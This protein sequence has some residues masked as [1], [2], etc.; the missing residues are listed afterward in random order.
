V[1][2]NTVRIEYNP[3]IF[4]KAI[5]QE[6]SKLYNNDLFSDFVIVSL[7]ASSKFHLTTKQIIGSERIK[8]HKFV[9]G[10]WSPEWREIIAKS[11]KNEVELGSNEEERRYLKIMIEF[12]YK[13]T[14][15]LQS[16]GTE[17]SLCDI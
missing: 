15:S 8:A 13:G 6:W 5:H 7:I 11:K 12:Q 14:V 9:L 10:C 4:G 16:Q 1:D 17:T 3:V 2:E